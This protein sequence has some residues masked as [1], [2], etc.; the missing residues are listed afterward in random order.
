MAGMIEVAKA[1]VT[2]VPNMQGSQKTITEDLTGVAASAGEKAG[3]AA[4]KG[5]AKS[6]G[7]AAAG[8]A[9]AA[10]VGSAMAD[11]W[12]E[13][14]AALDT[15]AVKTG[16]TGESLDSLGNS[17]KKV[18]ASLPTDFEAAGDAVGEVNTKF[19]LTGKELEDLSAQFIKFATINDTDVTNSVDNVA[20]ALNAFGQ[21]SSTASEVLDAMNAAGQA[22]G[23]GMDELGKALQKNAGTFV[24]LGLSVQ[25]AAGLMATFNQAGL[26]AADTSAALRM[27]LKNSAKAGMTMNE[28]VAKFGE[29]MDS[30][31]SSVDKLQAAINLFGAKAGPL[32]YNAFENGKINAESFSQAMSD[33]AGNVST[34]FDATIDPADR[35]QQAMN[36]LKT[37]GAELLDAVMPAFNAILDVAIPAVQKISEAFTNLPQGVQTAIVAIGGI[38]AVAGPLVSL[39]GGISGAFGKLGGLFSSIGGTASSAAGGL[40]TVASSAGTAATS[41]ASAAGGF[42]AMAGAALKIVALGAAFALVGAGLKL[43]ADGAVA[44]GQ[45]GFP[46]AMALLEMAAAVAALM[47]VAALLGPALTAGA[48]GIGVFGAAILAIGGGIAL[49]TTGIAKLVDAVG[50]LMEKTKAGGEGLNSM[51]DAVKRLGEINVFDVASGMSSI[52][53][54]IKDLSKN[55]EDITATATATDTLTTAMTSL[56]STAIPAVEKLAVSMSSVLASI[57]EDLQALSDAFKNTK[58]EF[59]TQLALPHFKMSGKFDAKSGT[60]PTVNVQWYAQAAE[61]GAIFTSPQL[62]GVGDA[63]Q[64]EMLVGERTLYD[65]IKDAVGQNGDVY[66]YIGDQQL[67]AI[68][69]RN[70]QRKSIRRGISGAY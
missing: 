43:M 49:A 1:T 51:V 40:S 38:A 16:A 68:I 42:G 26:T 27:A 7:K 47:G 22:T 55:S 53:K 39:A 36:S 24:Q 20:N 12:K 2:I 11:S 62:I 70:N 37:I 17:M 31:K 23:I 45:G 57:K 25:D 6:V 60:V 13:V 48:L 9:I 46:A 3:E 5:M 59:N 56:M 33:V 14:D 66:V 10:K 63:S 52:G 35:F 29:T 50:N 28:A 18:A 30:D 58:L 44:I 34:T 32:I 67:D 8:A 54:G 21:D 41:A 65:N 64:P 19:Q 15:V 4:G 61:Q 69:Q